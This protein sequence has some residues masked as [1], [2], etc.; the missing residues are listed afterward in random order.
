MKFPKPYTLKDIAASLI[1]STEYVGA[2]DFPC[3]WN[4]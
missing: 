3:S 2:D 4:E 1:I